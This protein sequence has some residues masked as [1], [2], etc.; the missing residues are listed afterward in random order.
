ML[1]FSVSGTQLSFR[2]RLLTA[3]NPAVVDLV[4]AQLPMNSVLGHV[5]ISGETF[6]IPTRIISLGPGNM[7][8]RQPG[9]VYY[10]SAGQSMCF[11]YG[12]ITESARVNKFGQVLQ[13][14]FDTLRAVGKLV[15]QQTV[16]SAKRN[17]VRV[18]I[19]LV[20][21]D[22]NR[23]RSLLRELAPPIPAA[24]GDWRATRARIEKEIDRVWLEEPDEVRR[25]R[26]GVVA[27]GAGTG[28][29]SFSV[30][31]HLETCLMMDGSGIV[32]RLLVAAQ[33]E[34][35]TIDDIKYLTRM[36]ILDIFNYFEFIEDLGL[37]SLRRVGDDYSDA[38]DTLKTKDEFIA[39]TSSLLTYVTR[40]HRWIHLIFPWQ[41]GAQFPHRA[42]ED[43]KGVPKL[44]TYSEFVDRYALHPRL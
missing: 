44:P 26:L 18:E 25:V 23:D 14:D 11:S 4:R 42:P 33:R 31:V 8:K 19:R 17:I 35:M 30:L 10:H 15:Y 38:L 1:R 27:G 7:V 5:V 16:A 28:G 39:L 32:Y 34:T 12:G 2:V 3:D 9:D 29:Q 36:F 21:G 41:L 13:E 24:G 43:V 40:M 20:G 37:P 22:A 6:W